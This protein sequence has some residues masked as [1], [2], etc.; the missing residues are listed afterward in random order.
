M[1]TKNDTK[2]EQSENNFNLLHVDT[3]QGPTICAC[4]NKVSGDE[5]YLAWTLQVNIKLNTIFKAEHS[6]Q[7]EMKSLRC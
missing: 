1:F 5:Q 3:A 2:Q 7:G 4:I 6:L